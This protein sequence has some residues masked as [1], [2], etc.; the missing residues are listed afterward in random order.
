MEAHGATATEGALGDLVATFVIGD[1]HGCFDTL[2]RLLARLPWD[3]STDRLWLTGDLV[4]RGPQSLEVLRWAKAQTDRVTAVLGNHDFHLLCVAAGYREIGSNSG[5]RAI[6]G[7]PDRDEILHWLRS[8]PLVHRERSYLLVHAGLHPDWSVRETESMAGEIEARLRGEHF[9]DFLRECS[10][11]AKKPVVWSRSLDGNERLMVALRIMTLLR[12]YTQQGDLL[13]K[14]GGSMAEAPAGAVPWFEAPGRKEGGI[15]YLFGHWAAQGLQ[16]ETHAIGL[17]SGCV[18]GG[19]LTALRLE[20][21][22][23]FQEPC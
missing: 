18:W 15:T 1:I 2:Q 9:E 11:H 6:L 7:A 14:F 17:D 8:R 23:L 5:L 10:K 12:V 16:L 20:D 4:N 3:P 19:T 13:L 21:R 22:A